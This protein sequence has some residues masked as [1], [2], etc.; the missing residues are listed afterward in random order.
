MKKIICFDFNGT[1]VNEG[2]WDFLTCGEK[3]LEKE[4]EDVFCLYKNNK[5]SINDFW[6]KTVLTLKKTGRANREYFCNHTDIVRNLKDGAEDLIRYLKEKEYRIYIVSCSIGEYLECLKQKFSLDGFY[7]GSNLVFDDKGELITIKSDCMKGA[8]FKERKLEE[9]VLKE[10]VNVED[11][12]FVGD[13][14]NDIGAFKMT[15]KGIAIDSKSEELNSV[16]WKKIKVLS[17][18]KEIL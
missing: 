5:I 7:A 15:K 18:I 17:E 6:D 16:A 11:I 9:L 12:V 3:E 1:L 8:S 14:N 4:L 2:S 13:G 10:N